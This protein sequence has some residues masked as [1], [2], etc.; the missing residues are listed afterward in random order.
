[1]KTKYNNV[2]KFE[3]VTTGE[4]EKIVD[5]LKPK[6]SYGSDNMSTKLMKSIKAA[7]INPLTIIIN[8]SLK[9]GIVPDKLK[10][11]LFKKDD[12]AVFSNYHPISLLPAIS[13]VL[14]R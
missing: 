10:I 14:K 1:M 2:F 4:I 13:K 7:L 8:Q 6:S 9:T 3:E 11:A 5:N 12:D